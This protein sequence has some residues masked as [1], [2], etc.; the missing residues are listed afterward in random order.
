MVKKKKAAALLIEILEKKSRT[1]EEFRGEAEKIGI[2]RANFFIQRKNLEKK[3]KIKSLTDFKTGEKTWVTI[4]D[5]DKANLDDIRLCFDEIKNENDKLRNLG[6]DEFVHLCQTKL[7]THD[8]RVRLFFKKAFNDSSL[9]N[10]HERVLLAFKYVLARTL[11]DGNHELLSNLLE[12]NKE[13]IKKFAKV[14][15]IKWENGCLDV[16]SV[17]LKKKALY[18][19]SLVRDKEVLDIL[20]D[21]IEKSSTEEY[22]M[23]KAEILDIFRSYPK[24]HRSEIKRGIY[25]IAT[26]EKNKEEI[27]DR[28]INLLDD[29]SDLGERILF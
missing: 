25:R 9:G 1:S 18:V 17:R 16:G 14:I 2:K 29:L 5:D 10:A 21:L 11:E 23:L 20:F 26:K 8:P 15:P 28:A 6:V 3:G 13:V 24:E 12:E 22:S 27:I 7:V 4:Q 19:L